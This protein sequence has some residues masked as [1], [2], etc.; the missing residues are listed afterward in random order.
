MVARPKLKTME[1]GVSAEN[2]LMV[3]AFAMAVIAHLISGRDAARTDSRT[4]DKDKEF[5]Y[6][7]KTYSGTHAIAVTAKVWDLN[8]N[9]TEQ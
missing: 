4:V 7:R 8:I 1:M 2:V 6:S 5:D 3:I 9:P